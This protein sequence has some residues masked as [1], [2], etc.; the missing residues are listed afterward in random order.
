MADPEKAPK[1]KHK[2]KP[3]RPLIFCPRCGNAVR[4]SVRRDEAMIEEFKPWNH[5]V[6]NERRPMAPGK[7]CVSKGKWYSSVTVIEDPRKGNLPG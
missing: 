3:T 5:T 2:H 6:V 1:K 7:E 4:A